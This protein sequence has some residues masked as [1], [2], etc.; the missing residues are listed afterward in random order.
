MSDNTVT[1]IARFGQKSVEGNSLIVAEIDGYMHLDGDGQERHVFLPGEEVFF[2]LHLDPDV[3]II[4][5]KATDD[6]DVGQ[7]GMVTRTR[8]QQLSFD[9]PNHAI[10]LPYRPSGPLDAKWYGRSSSLLL[11]GLSVKASSAPCLGDVS[12]PITAMQYVHRPLNGVVL[13]PGETFPVDLK[14]EYTVG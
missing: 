3:K 8:T 13:V 7:V 11:S 2:L 4:R 5:I 6:G 12:F 1:A 10:T 9:N 14:I